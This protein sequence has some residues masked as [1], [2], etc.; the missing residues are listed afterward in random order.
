MH[1]KHIMSIE[2]KTHYINIVLHFLLSHHY[3]IQCIYITFIGGKMKYICNY[4]KVFKLVTYHYLLV[5]NDS[6]K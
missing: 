2:L 1:I 6:C 4:M 3:E 5:L